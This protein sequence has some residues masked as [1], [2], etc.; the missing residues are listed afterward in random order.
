MSKVWIIFE[1]EYLQRVQKKSFILSTLLT[2]LIFPLFIF[3]AVLLIES[4]EQEIRRIAVLDNSGLIEDTVSFGYNNMYLSN[5]DIN[6]LQEEIINGEIYGALVIP[7]LDI[8]NPEPINFYSKNVP[9]SDFVND[10]ENIVENKI[11]DRKIKELNIEKSS[12]EK[13][14]TRVDMDTYHG[15]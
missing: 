2:P 15:G 5:S 6:L 13:L 8:Y 1:R 12:L 11:K 9:S 10:I 14:E 3:I 7:K 4:D